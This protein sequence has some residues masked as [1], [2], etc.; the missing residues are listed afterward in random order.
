M[1]REILLFTVLLF[2]I[3]KIL[4]D[5]WMSVDLTNAEDS[6]P[7]HLLASEGNLKATKA[8]FERDCIISS[9]W[10]MSDEWNGGKKT[11]SDYHG[12]IGMTVSTFP[13]TNWGQS[14]VP[15]SGHAVT[16]RLSYRSAA[17]WRWDLLELQT[18]WAVIYFRMVR[19]LKISRFS[20]SCLWGFLC[21]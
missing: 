17:K 11:Y 8:L 6:T 12:L 7:L 19:N 1:L 15:Q 4:L 5:K 18:K 14:W 3:I 9:G 20:Q 13:R 10:L 16:H 2:Q 21:S